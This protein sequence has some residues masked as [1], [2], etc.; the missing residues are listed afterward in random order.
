MT[1]L[2]EMGVVIKNRVNELGIPITDFAEKLGLS[3]HDVERVYQ[4]RL[5]LTPSQIETTKELLALTS[6]EL[7]P[8]DNP[9]PIDK[10]LNIVD[11]FMDLL[12]SLSPTDNEGNTHES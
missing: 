3:V 4:A 5:I 7:L 1:Q 2:R 12:E 9:E 11:D 6:D 8:P 10:V